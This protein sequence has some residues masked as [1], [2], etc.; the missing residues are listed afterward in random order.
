MIRKSGLAFVNVLA[1]KATLAP[2]VLWNR[3]TSKFEQSANAMPP[4][5]VTDAGIVTLTKLL[6]PWNVCP[7]S[8]LPMDTI[9]SGMVTEVSVWFW[10]NAKSPN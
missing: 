1:G 2:L 9:V 10:K 5:V 6:A 7:R 4:I 3:A 8:A